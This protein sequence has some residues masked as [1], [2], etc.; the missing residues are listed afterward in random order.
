M[1]LIVARLSRRARTIPRKSP[2]TSVRSRFHRDVA[3]R[4]HRDPDPRLS[5]R[6]RVVDAV[7][8]HGD[9]ST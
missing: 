8:R 2:L 3:A 5:E 4:P 7:A 1:F 9:R 6:G